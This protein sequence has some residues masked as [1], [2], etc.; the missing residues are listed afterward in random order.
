[1]NFAMKTSL[2]KIC[3]SF[4]VIVFCS[5]PRPLS[6]F[7]TIARA[8]YHV[9]V[10]G[11]VEAKSLPSLTISDGSGPSPS[12]GERKKNVIHEGGPLWGIMTQPV[13]D[14]E[15]LLLAREKFNTK[16]SSENPD[17]LRYR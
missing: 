8:P 7:H 5:S 14:S 13:T 3:F 17:N 9:S 11:I 12:L 6:L 4:F 10:P 1:M 15:M 2:T 16:K